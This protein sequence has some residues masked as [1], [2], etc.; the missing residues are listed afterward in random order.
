[1]LNTLSNTDR[2]AA[3]PTA[4]AFGGKLKMT[5][6]TL[7]A[8]PVGAAQV[9]QLER[10]GGERLG[11]LG[12][13]LH[14]A[15]AFRRR[16]GA[17]AAAAGAGDAR[18]FAA[19]AE[20]RRHGRTVQ[21][22][23][24]DHHRRFERQQAL[25]T[26][27][28]R[29]QRLE[30]ERMR[31][32]VRQVELGERLG[33]GGRVVVRRAADE[34]EARQRDHRVDHRLAVADEELVDRRARVEPARKGGNDAQAAILERLDD[35][36]VMAGV[37]AEDVRPQDEHP[38]RAANR[39]RRARQVG[40]ALRHPARHRRVIDAEFGI[41]GRGGGGHRPAQRPAR[42][43][44]VAVD[45]VADEVGEILVRPRQ[46]VLQRQEIGADVLRGAGD[47]AQDLGQALQHRHLPRPRRRGAGLRRAAQLLQQ[48][49][50]PL[51]G[52]VHPVVAEPRQL[53]DRGVAH[54]PDDRVAV[55]RAVPR[56]RASPRGYDRRGTA[57]RR[58]RCRPPRCRRGRR[59]GWR[60]SLPSRRRRGSA[61]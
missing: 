11:A 21:L 29:L 42:A 3:V 2:Y 38:D 18:P 47:E 17:A 16:E 14:D 43:V 45:E 5:S 10:A 37:V 13:R 52:L 20:H 58:R 25:R 48:R 57:S 50:R 53:D 8:R 49:Q 55:V 6:A 59:R 39:P 30:L 61:G 19:P 9:D 4:P 44:G 7:R 12:A 40:G 34:A 35:A 56:A 36:V 46:P 33:G 26:L 32:E 22:G 15:R 54:Q 24:G 23:D 28:P 41:V 31:G 1:M 60:G 27:A 51:G